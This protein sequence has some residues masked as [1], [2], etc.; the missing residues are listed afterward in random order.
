M[1]SLLAY[2]FDEEPVR[3]V[4]IAG[5]PW[6]VA[7]D[8]ARVLGYSHAPHMVRNLEEDELGVHIVDTSGGNREMNIISESGLYA[9]IMRSR[10]PDARRFRKWVTGEVLPSI[11]RTG[12]YELP[13]AEPPPPLA[14]DHDPSRLVASVSVVR[15]ARRLFGPAGA[16]NIWMQL[17]LPQPIA[18]ASGSFDGDPWAEP[19]KE[20]LLGQVETTVAAIGEAIG[21][22]RPDYTGRQRLRALLK[23][24]GWQE[25]VVSREHRSAR[26][27]FPPVSVREI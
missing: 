22:G 15:E 21:V 16:R 8:V 24:Y 3:V 12:R 5:T 19:V 6:F 4:M 17:G 14:N 2:Q 20:F 9:V 18:D 11:R 23:L 25:R 27:W 10:R 26:R 7:N 13:G 1:N